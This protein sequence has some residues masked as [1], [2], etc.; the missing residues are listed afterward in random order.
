M[1]I[2]KRYVF[3]IILR[4]KTGS[5][6]VN[7]FFDSERNLK[8]FRRIMARVIVTHDDVPQTPPRDRRRNENAPATQQAPSTPHRLRRSTR[9]QQRYESD[10]NRMHPRVLFN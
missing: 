8:V 4:Q 6:T 10:V 5:S 3:R 9:L 1:Y 7:T 2:H